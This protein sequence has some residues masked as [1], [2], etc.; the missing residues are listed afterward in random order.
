VLPEHI[1]QSATQ[2]IIL[3]PEAKRI[4][5]A[6]IILFEDESILIINKPPGVNVHPGDHKSKEVSIIEL[7]QDYLRA[8]P[9][10]GLFEPALVHRI[11][12]DTSGVLIV[13]KNRLSLNILLEELQG[14]EMQKYYLALVAGTIT[15]TSGRIDLPLLRREVER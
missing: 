14:H 8:T 5:I 3:P 7:V 6:N 2:P 9:R 10:K 13:A 11:D 4:D 15:P 1:K 12:R